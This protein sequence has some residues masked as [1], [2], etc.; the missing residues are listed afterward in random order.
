MHVNTREFEADRYAAN[1]TSSSTLKKGLREYNKLNSKDIDDPKYAKRRFKV[2][3]D[4]ID[5]LDY[6]EDVKKQARENTMKN[7]DTIINT[8]NNTKSTIKKEQNRQSN[9]DY[10]QRQKALKDKSLTQKEKD[11]YR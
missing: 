5:D 11:N 8:I 2:A 1:K 10:N 7:K 4:S 6:D 9:E 3:L